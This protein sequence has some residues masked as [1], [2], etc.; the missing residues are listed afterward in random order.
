MEINAG[1]KQTEIGV[2]PED[3]NVYQ[4]DD[5]GQ[6]IIGLTYSP[7]DVSSSGK[8]VHRSSNIQNNRLAFYDNVY[9]SST[10]PEKLI[11][12]NNDILICVRNGSKQLIGKSVLIKGKSIGETF[13]AF[14]S[15][16]RPRVYAPLLYQ[17]FISNIVQ[18]QI[19]A[20]LG[21]TINQ[22]TNKTLN[23]FLTPFPPTLKEQK[24]I[25]TALSDVDNLIT[26]LD[27]LITKKKA[28]K[29]GAMQRLLT[30]PHIGGK[31]LSG[32]D[33]EWVE[34]SLGSVV[35]YK[36]GAAHENCVV[37]NGDFVI[38]NSKFV[39]TEGR[40]VK[41][42]DENRC[43][44]NKDEILMVLSDVPNGKAIAKCYYVET[45]DK[46][47]LNQRI[48]SFKTDR[49]DPKFL[50]LILNRNPYY[51]KFDDGVKQTNL[52]NEDV[53]S[54]PLWLPP[55]KEEQQAISEIIHEMNIQIESL[56]TKKQK[57]QGIKQGMMQELLT[58][59]TR[60]V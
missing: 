46:Y 12:R 8:L 22:I 20:S 15:V 6:A 57:Y 43:P 1:Y 24:A 51:L 31:R 35:N 18:H 38:V 14:M 27:H 45:D 17:Y 21:A 3:W 40:V 36:N 30:P 29:Q 16:F 42:S 41:Y 50:F 34:K 58:G 32:F 56:E 49:V 10:I 5:L 13:G 2:I 60:L 33:G 4:F 28:I 23:E 48:C 25:A 59:K 53:L 39:S 7:N 54:C 52:R 44:V 37:K 26:N 55:T 9:V 47:T 11:L 19:T